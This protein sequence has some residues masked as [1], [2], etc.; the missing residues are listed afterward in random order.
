MP[1]NQITVMIYLNCTLYSA[2]NFR[3]LLQLGSFKLNI[4]QLDPRV[5]CNVIDAI[6]YKA[7]H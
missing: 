2:N 7:K 3:K 1:H 5:Q 4:P 6:H